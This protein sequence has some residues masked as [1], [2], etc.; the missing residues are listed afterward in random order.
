[1]LDRQSVKSTAQGANFSGYDGHKKVKGHKRH[2]LVDT[3]GLLLAVRL[4]PADVGDRRG[5]KACLVGKK[6]FVP[7]LETI[8]ADANYTGDDLA[9]TCAVAGW[10]LEIVKR[11]QRRFEVQPKRWMVER[12]LA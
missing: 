3:L 1:M 4:T 2:V 7:R 6:V 5:V 9:R 10:E 8:W 12:T 11:P